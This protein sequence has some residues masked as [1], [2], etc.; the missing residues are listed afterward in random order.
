MR[1]SSVAR[2]LQVAVAVL[3]AGNAAL[4]SNGPSHDVQ[5]HAFSSTPLPHFQP[6]TVSDNGPHNQP[7]TRPN[8][9]AP[10]QPNIIVMLADDLGWYDT[11]IHN[12]ASPTPRI[13]KLARVE[14]LVL[15]R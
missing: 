5:K 15:D 7:V 10:A 11:A 1:T 4:P 6:H 2:V 14:G 9:Q 12:P 13:E 3:S 8:A